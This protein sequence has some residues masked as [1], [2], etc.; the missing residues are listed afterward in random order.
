MPS[1]R[2]RP[3]DAGGACQAPPLR[4]RRVPSRHPPGGTR[5]APSSRCFLVFH[6]RRSAPRW[7]NETRVAATGRFGALA[8]LEEHLPG[9]QAVAGPS[10]A[11][12]TR[13]DQVHVGHRRAAQ[14]GPL[15]IGR[16]SSWVRPLARPPCRTHRGA[17]AQLGR[18]SRSHRA[19]RRFNSGQLHAER[20]GSTSRAPVEGDRRKRPAFLLGQG[21]CSGPPRADK[22]RGGEPAV[23]C[24][25]PPGTSAAVMPKAGWIRR[26]NGRLD[27]TSLSPPGTV[28][29][30]RPGIP[31]R[32][33]R[34]RTGQLDGPPRHRPRQDAG[35]GRPDAAR[36]LTAP[37]LVREGTDGHRTGPGPMPGR[38]VGR[39]RATGT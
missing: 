3:W 4:A 21:H 28:Q 2:E 8:Q 29:R 37:P 16:A 5:R 6:M 1:H 19:G 39:A 30:H 7:A 32:R 36:H 23:W 10:P 27:G 12:S 15:V 13:R 38:E 18:A 17:V 14:T 22:T 24:R 25:G 9:R 26:Q 31:P 34:P 11:G 35:T 33:D 20:P